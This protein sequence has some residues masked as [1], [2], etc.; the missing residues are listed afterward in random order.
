MSGPVL[1]ASNLRVRRGG[2]LVLNV[3]A[4]QIQ[5]GEVFSIIGPNG[6]GK[7][8]LLQALCSLLPFEGEL[9]FRGR[10]IGQEIPVL[11]YRRKVAMV[12]QE[13]L[14]FN[15]TVYRNVASGLKIRDIKK[16]DAEG[17]VLSTLERLG[18]RELKD[19]A[20]RTLSGGEA[21]KV[22]LARAI[23]TSPELLF[24]D[25]P[26]SAL[27]PVIR[28]A[29]IEDLEQ[30][31]EETKI[32][33]LFVTHDREEALRL[34]TRLGVMWRGEILQAGIPR[35]VMDH[36]VDEHVASLVGMET[37]LRGE[38]LRNGSGVFVASVSGREIEAAGQRKKGEKVLL[39]I[40]AENI[41]LSPLDETDTA[42]E[43]NSFPA[44]IEKIVPL[45]L[46]RKVFLNCGFPL[47]A[48]VMDQD[49]NAFHLK[50]G[51]AVRASFSKIH[52]IGEESG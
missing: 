18:I 7:S 22:S 25:E 1:E 10:K 45:W 9:S 30:V 19:R 6:A 48:Y 32:T 35:E 21:R 51:I 15:T 49:S 40:R 13:P 26:F 50:E 52:V 42:G 38:V 2:T 20:A 5:K 17:I 33:T 24:L 11:Q 28:E 23:A 34:S 31:I 3:P 8:T 37:I 29:L 16:R 44:R 12:L 46:Y 14:L 47:V 36:P 41:R 39:C 27:D 4:L 43:V